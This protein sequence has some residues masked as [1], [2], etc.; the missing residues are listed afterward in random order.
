MYAQVDEVRKELKLDQKQFDKVYSAYEK[1]DKVVFGDSDS[2]DSGLGRPQ[3]GGPGKGGP[4]GGRVWVVPVERPENL[5]KM[6]CR[7]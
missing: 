2:R 1:F 5:D 6:A 4:G 7:H 3:G